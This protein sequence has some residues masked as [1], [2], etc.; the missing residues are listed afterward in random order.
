MILLDRISVLLVFL[1]TTFSAIGQEKNV[2]F[3]Y[4]TVTTQQ[5]SGYYNPNGIS[6]SF[7][8][9]IN[10]KNYLTGRESNSERT[11][12]IQQ[13]LDKHNKVVLPNYP[14]TVSTKGLSLKSNSTLIFQPKSQ[15]IMENNSQDYYQLLKVHGVSNVKIYNANLKGD[16]KGHRSKSGEW[17]YGIS[18]RSAKDILIQNS[19]ITDF[20]GDGIAIG[21]S[22]TST[23]SNIE[24]RNAFID[25]NRR[26][27]ISVMNV[28]GLLLENIYVSNTNG[29]LPMFGIDFEPNNASDNLNNIRINN[30][31]SYNNKM[32]GLMITFNNLKPNSAKNILFNI[33]NF[34]DDSSHEGIL[35]AGIPKTSKNLKGQINLNNITLTRNARPLTGRTIHNDNVV[36]NIENLDVRNPKNKNISHAEVDRV[37]KTKKNYSIKFRR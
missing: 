8:G 13:L 18:I 36:V 33:N 27:G 5:Y 4:R 19:K 35:I 34:S 14:I 23:N 6:T 12:K 1:I 17:G 10:A 24:I 20:W 31:Q 30:I 15:L 7:E 29:T 2:A 25:N 22:N 11:N 21:Y 32:G 28:N 26:N 9:A 37:F 3:S 16:R